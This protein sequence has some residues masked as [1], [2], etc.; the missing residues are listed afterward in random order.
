MFMNCQVPVGFQI[1]DFFCFFRLKGMLEILRHFTIAGGWLE[2]ALKC[3]SL[4]RNAGDLATMLH[5][6]YIADEIRS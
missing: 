5:Y 3:W 6:T 2:I 1:E 4:Q